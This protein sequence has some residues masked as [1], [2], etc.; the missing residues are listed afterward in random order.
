MTKHVRESRRL[1]SPATPC[2][3]CIQNAQMR[4]DE[5]LA[6]RMLD[7]HIAGHLLGKTFT[8]NDLA[9]PSSSTANPNTY[10]SERPFNRSVLYVVP[11][12][13]LRQ[14]KAFF[15][16][17]NGARPRP[18]CVGSETLLCDHRRLPFRVLRP[19]RANQVPTS[20]NLTKIGII[21]DAAFRG[22]AA[23]YGDVEAIALRLSSENEIVSQ[24]P[25]CEQ[26]EAE[27]LSGKAEAAF[28]YSKG[29]I[30]IKHLD[31][32]E[33]PGSST[34]STAQEKMEANNRSAP[35]DVRRSSRDRL[36]SIKAVSEVE[37]LKSFHIFY[38]TTVMELKLSIMNE[39]FLSAPND[40]HLYYNGVELTNDE[41][42]QSARVPSGAQLEVKVDLALEE[43]EDDLQRAI[44]ASMRQGSPERGFEGTGLYG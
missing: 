39:W 35:G 38:N 24:P 25:L 8:V 3:L 11:H 43:D 23:T 27:G 22:L 41:T 18:F 20:T 21:D 44:L 40:Q 33:D 2:S 28:K 12:T 29:I 10:S 7:S 42:M 31:D 16:D 19:E 6:Q 13:F 30:K 5:A 36:A 1:D 17:K 14:W 15:G 9:M 26:C 37:K 34:V 4:S 32:D